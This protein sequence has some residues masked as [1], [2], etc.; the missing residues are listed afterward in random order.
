[1]RGQVEYVGVAVSLLATLW[2]VALACATGGNGKRPEPV[3]DDPE[4]KRRDAMVAS[5]IEARGVRDRCTL[6]A[7][8]HV[9]RPLFIPPE[10]RGQAY[11]DG[12]VAI[13][14][15]QTIS[16][17]YIVALMTELVRPQRGMRVLEIG[18]G[19]GY[20][21]AVLAECVGEVYTI[22]IVPELGRRAAA[23]LGEL[24]YANIRFRIGDGFDGWPEAAPFDAIVVTAAPD[25]IPKPLLDQLAVGGR[26][27]IPVGRGSQ[28]LLL[29]TRTESG[30]QREEVIPVRFVPMTGKAQE[31]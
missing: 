26:L 17:P 3:D 24:G 8:R 10:A 19:S 29:V 16:Q 15:G 23:V 27:V 6:A 12:P 13:G 14:E 25:E 2:L 1:V 20:Q 4:A 11:V 5:Q 31:R 28:D 9:P 7:L 22:E 18:T 21:A 30:Y